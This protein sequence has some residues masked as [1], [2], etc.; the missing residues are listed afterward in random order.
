MLDRSKLAFSINRHDDGGDMW[1]GGIYLHIDDVTTINI[2]ENLK[3]FD[4]FISAL[5]GMRDEIEE[6]LNE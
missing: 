5:N 6:N 1:E 3:D 4:D 2:G